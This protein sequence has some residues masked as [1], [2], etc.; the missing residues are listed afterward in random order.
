MSKGGKRRER[1]S[2]TCE[3]KEQCLLTNC[4]SLLVSS[5]SHFTLSWKYIYVDADTCVMCCISLVSLFYFFAEV[6]R[7]TKGDTEVL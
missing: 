7:P 5:E 4:V 6:S 1:N 2:M 3:S